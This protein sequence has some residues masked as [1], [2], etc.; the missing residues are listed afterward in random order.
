MAFTTAMKCTTVAALASA[1][2]TARLVSRR[3]AKTV[4]R[5]APEET[6]TSP[7][8]GST[9]F[10]AGKSYSEAEWNAAVASGAV[11]Q[12]Q[13][14][15]PSVAQAQALSLGDI[16]AFSGPGP[17]IINGRLAMLAFVAALGAELSSGESVVRQWAEEP[18]GVTLTF[19]VFIAAS[20]IPLINSAKREAFGPFTPAAELLNG[21][22]AMIG[23][24]SLLAVEAIR[25]AA[26]F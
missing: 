10:F 8:V 9:Y 23:F 15:P 11:S 1:R 13:R 5:S 2:P 19:V 16:M 22:A 26:L 25:G 4:V 20:L 12:P 17:E 6:T 3:V 21:R 14:A 7:E 18:T 24:A